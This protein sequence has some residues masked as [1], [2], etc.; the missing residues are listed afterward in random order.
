MNYLGRKLKASRIEAGFDTPEAIAPGMGVSA[1]SV[2]NWETGRHRISG[3]DLGKW[4]RLCGKPL[5]YFTQDTPAATELPAEA[6][7]HP[8]VDALAADARLCHAHRITHEELGHLAQ[9][10][11]AYGAETVVMATAQEALAMLQAL[12]TFGAGGQ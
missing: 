9:L 10:R 8:G 6:P 1:Q 12:R 11:L 3:E 5:D 7:N 4:A 2:R